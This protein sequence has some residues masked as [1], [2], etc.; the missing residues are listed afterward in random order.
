MAG[1]QCGKEK[2]APQRPSSPPALFSP[3]GEDCRTAGHQELCPGLPPPRHHLCGS[4]FCLQHRGLWLLP[5]LSRPDLQPGPPG[6]PLLPA[7][8]P[9]VHDELRWETFLA[10]ARP[11]PGPVRFL[12]QQLR[13]TSFKPPRP[14][15]ILSGILW[16]GRFFWGGGC[17]NDPL[18]GLFGTQTRAKRGPIPRLSAFD[19]GVCPWEGRLRES[20]WWEGGGQ[21]PPELGGRGQRRLQ[22]PRLSFRGLGRPRV[23]NAATM[24]RR[25]SVM[26]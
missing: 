26:Q 14:G 1:H 19:Q 17:C 12:G 13:A 7:R 16:F 6:W 5:G 3:A 25:T 2:A 11:P 21:E 23:G 4:L 22:V 18:F 8:V 9:R 20:P 10:P 15:A 24:G